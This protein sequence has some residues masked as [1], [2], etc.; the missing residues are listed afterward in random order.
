MKEYERNHKT[1]EKIILLPQRR[2][3]C[4]EVTNETQR[5]NVFLCLSKTKD[6]LRTMVAKNEATGET[7][8]FIAR[9]KALPITQKR[10]THLSSQ[11]G[12]KVNV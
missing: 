9:L 3:A 5:K 4:P 7:F 11:R 1:T 12:R 6:R 2:K 10:I 8:W